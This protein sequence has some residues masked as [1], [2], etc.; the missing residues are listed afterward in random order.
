MSVSTLAMPMPFTAPLFV[1]ASDASGVTKKDVNGTSTPYGQIG[2]VFQEGSVLSSLTGPGGDLDFDLLAEYLL[3]EGT[4][5]G[6]GLDKDKALPDFSSQVAAAAV[7]EASSTSSDLS[8][9]NQNSRL[10][11]PQ[12]VPRKNGTTSNTISQAP[13]SSFS[14]T[15]AQGA[16]I[17]RPQ[18]PVPI[19]VSKSSG[20]TVLTPA[21]APVYAA[22]APLTAPTHPVVMIPAPGTVVPYN[23]PMPA[24]NRN[25][26]GQYIMTPN[27]LPT[28]V[29]HQH[30]PAAALVVSSAPG[31]NKRPRGTAGSGLQ[32]TSRRQKTQAQIDRRRERNR[33]LARRTRLRKKFFFESLQKEVTD[34]QRENLALKEIV[35]TKIGEQDAD[36]AKTILGQCTANGNLPSVIAES[37]GMDNMEDLDK[38]D[39]SLVRCLQKSQQSFV[40]TDPSL[41]D[42]PIVY[43]SEGFLYITGYSRDEVLGRNCRFLQGTD[44]CPLKV[45]K[46]KNA[47][48]NAED[49]S[50]CLLNY[51]ADGTPFWNQLFIAALRDANNNIVNFVGVI[52]K[53]ASPSPDDPEAGEKLPGEDDISEDDADLSRTNEAIHEKSDLVDVECPFLR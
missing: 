45:K 26:P 53:V 2:K 25:T 14:K 6:G 20:T 38:Q 21:P 50:V 24:L 31:S 17:L 23:H 37:C 43:A 46:V 40:I 48:S 4:Q 8:S 22:P 1:S 18:N 35:K 51:T 44:T 33:I 9:Q 27:Q 13:I 12:P 11:Q 52:C 49:V 41:Q 34:L 3:D 28:M 19:P 16:P 7:S 39:F 42:N 10:S 29:V 5:F 15:T 30:R 47:L 36:K 32:P